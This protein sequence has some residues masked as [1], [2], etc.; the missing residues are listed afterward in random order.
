[1]NLNNLTRTLSGSLSVGTGVALESLL[2][3][4][5]L[6]NRIDDDREVPKVK[7]NYKT[8]TISIQ[9][10][11]RNI[12]SSHE[13]KDQVTILGDREG[14][15]YI[16]G[17][18]SDEVFILESMQLDMSVDF[19]LLDYKDKVFEKSITDYHGNKVTPNRTYRVYTLAN[20]IAKELVKSKPLIPVVSKPYGLLMTHLPYE[21]FN[22][23]IFESHTGKIISKTN[24]SKYYK[25]YKGNDLVNIPFTKTLLYMLGGKNLVPGILSISNRKKL[26]EL[27]MQDRWSSSSTSIRIEHTLKKDKELSVIYKDSKKLFV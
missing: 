16:Y 6:R 24:L 22:H 4:E 9:T 5:F 20:K 11:V 17:I 2:P 26:V 7:N 19:K 25:Q 23:D 27:A 13:A 8:L 21:M 3:T 14:F 1:M 15:N 10:L 18:V 12:I